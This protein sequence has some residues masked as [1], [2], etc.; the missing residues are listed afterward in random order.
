MSGASFSLTTDG[1][2]SGGLLYSQSSLGKP[3]REDLIQLFLS[4]ADNW[5]LQRPFEIIREGYTIR[6]RIWTN[7]LQGVS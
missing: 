2:S 4:N 6:I 7:F 5:G 3:T 1:T